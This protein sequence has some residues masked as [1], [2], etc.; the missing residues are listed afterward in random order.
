MQ[1]YNSVH[2]VTAP[3]HAPG[4]SR[5]CC[6]LRWRSHSQ[7]PIQCCCGTHTGPQQGQRHR[8]GRQY[9]LPFH[10]CCASSSVKKLI[11]IHIYNIQTGS[12]VSLC[13]QIH[14][15]LCSMCHCRNNCWQRPGGD[16][17]IQGC[18]RSGQGRCQGHRTVREASGQQGMTHNLNYF[19]NEKIH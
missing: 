15:S 9:V 2:P 8:P 17:Q 10:H 5:S 11:C 1:R 7:E 3:L 18:R 14:S 13:F 12:G 16:C 19:S 6:D 4:S